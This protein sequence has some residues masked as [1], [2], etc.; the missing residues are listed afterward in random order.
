VGEIF[1]D[2]RRGLRLGDPVDPNALHDVLQEEERKALR[3]GA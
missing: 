2:I 1:E 3:Q